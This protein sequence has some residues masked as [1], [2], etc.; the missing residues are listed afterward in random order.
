[1]HVEFFLWEIYE[2]GNRVFPFIWRVRASQQ[3]AGIYHRKHFWLLR[4]LNR[5]LLWLCERKF[6]KISQHINY[7]G[8]VQ[9]KSRDDERSRFSSRWL[10][11]PRQTRIQISMKAFIISL[12]GFLSNN[13]CNL[14]KVAAVFCIFLCCPMFKDYIFSLLQ[15]SK[16]NNPSL[17]SRMAIQWYL[18][19]NSWL[20]SLHPV[21]QSII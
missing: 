21:T 11:S 13:T 9:L 17:S 8:K 19:G 1:M 18:H 12:F 6:L 15:H 10:P 4:H 2:F 16:D 7:F 3:N 20:V 14:V 5:F